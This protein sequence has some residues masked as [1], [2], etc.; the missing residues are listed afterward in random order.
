MKFGKDLIIFDLECTGSDKELYSICEIGA[1][2]VCRVS[3]IIIDEFQSLVKPYINNFE[4]EAMAVHKIPIEM[5]QKAPDINIVLDKFENWIAKGN[6]SKLESNELACRKVTLAGW[7]AS[8]FDVPF[9]QEAYK[10]I[11]R[12][13]PF[14]Y[15]VIDVKTIV[16]W[17]FAKQNKPFRGGLDK[18]SRR[19]NFTMEGTHHRAIDDAKT[20]ARILSAISYW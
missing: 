12:P 3:L 17:E 14:D 19:L 2:R 1:V 11:N 4:P 15:K 9:L 13:W 5:L 6:N 8:Y 7:G 16:R 10:I 18:C 20:T